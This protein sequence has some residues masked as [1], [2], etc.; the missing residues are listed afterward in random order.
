M[1][2]K[3]Y[4]KNNFL[5]LIPIFL[6]NIFLMDYLPEAYGS[7]IFW[8]DIPKFVGIGE[9]ILRII[10]FVL[11]A[12]MVFSLKSRMQR[13][14]FSIYLIGTIIY[15]LS[16]LMVIILPESNWSQS[17]LGFMAPAY[18]TIIWFIGIGLIGKKA[19]FKIPYLSHIYIG[20]SILFVV[21]HTLH[22]Y[23]VFMNL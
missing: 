23:I 12:I 8:K 2:I 4:I 5:L 11:P 22:T 10:V 3:K 18:T 16:W 9:N 1:K 13:I 14:G 19:C 7:D 15:F 17:L 20:F 21:F 6:W